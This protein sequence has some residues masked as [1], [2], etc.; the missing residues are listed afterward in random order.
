VRVESDAVCPYCFEA[1][2][3]WIDLGGGFRQDYI[4]D[5]AICCRPC[6]VIVSEGDEGLPFVQ[7][8]RE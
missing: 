2:S 5:C 4:E 6:R 7:M 8:Q 3:V 1:V